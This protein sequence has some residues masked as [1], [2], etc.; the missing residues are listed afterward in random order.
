M[1]TK[2]IDS[3]G[4]IL[5]RKYPRRVLTSLL[6]LLT[7]P[8]RRTGEWLWCWMGDPDIR[9]WEGACLRR[10]HEKYPIIDSVIDLE[11]D[12]RNTKIFNNLHR[13]ILNACE[14]Y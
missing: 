13:S 8:K 14:A 10:H 12:Y 7:D 4:A 1:P 3:K 9:R 5:R 6:F 11:S 2:H